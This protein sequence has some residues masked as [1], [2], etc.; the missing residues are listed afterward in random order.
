MGDQTIGVGPDVDVGREP[1]L[2]DAAR[3]G[4]VRGQHQPE[5]APLRQIQAMG[6]D[7]VGV[8]T[9]LLPNDGQKHLIAFVPNSPASP[10]GLLGNPRETGT[11]LIAKGIGLGIGEVS[12]D[13]VDAR[14]RL[15]HRVIIGMKCSADPQDRATER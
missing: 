12:S 9:L 14:L 2:P 5:L 4:E 11:D 6:E 8:D 13:V 1:G 3:M 15:A 7:S 10:T